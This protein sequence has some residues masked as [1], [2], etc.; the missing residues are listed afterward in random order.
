MGFNFNT[1][2]GWG[3]TTLLLFL[4]RRK[5]NSSGTD[6]KAEDMQDTNVN[7][8]GSPVPVVLGRAMVKSPLISYYGDF[9]GDIYTE[10]YGMHTA[11][12]WASLIPSV[13]FAILAFCSQPSKVV[14]QVASGIPVQ[15]GHYVGQTTGFGTIVQANTVEEGAKNAKIIATV[16]SILLQILTALFSNHLGRTTIQKGFKYYLGW[17][18]IICWSGKNIGIK[19]IWMDVYDADIEDCTE[20]GVWGGNIAWKADNPSGIDVYI[21]DENMFGGIDEGGGFI[22]HIHVY[23]GGKAQPKDDWMINQMK[24]D[25]IE[26]DLR[27]LT[28]QYPMYVTAVIP[29]AY[30]GKRATIPEMWFEIVN[31][32]DTLA[33]E[34]K[35]YL[36]NKFN[37][38]KAKYQAIIDELSP[39]PNVDKTYLQK[40]QLANAQAHIDYLN[41]KTT[42]TLGRLGDDL[43]PAE[44]IYEVLINNHWG[45][46]YSRDNKIDVESLLDLGITC[47]RE[48]LG[49]S[50]QY[51]RLS[52]ADT[53][54]SGILNHIN[55]VKYDDPRTGKL[56]FKLIRN[57]YDDAELKVFDT[58][59]CVDM[60][61]SR[62]DW[63]ETV[64]SVS[65][66]FIDASN[67][68]LEGQ[69]MCV[70]VAN[71]KITKNQSEESIDASYFTTATNAK[72][73]AQNQLLSLAYPLS[74]VEIECNRAGYDVVVGE[75]IIVTWNPYGISKMVFRVTSIDYGSL[76]SGNIKISAIE[77]V[78]GF[79]KLEYSMAHGLDWV[80]PTYVPFDIERF[81]YIE[82]PYELT[83]S[84][85]TYL[86]AL[87]IQPSSPTVIWDVWKEVDGAFVTTARSSTWSFGGKLQYQVNEEYSIDNVT[88]IEII[89]IGYNSTYQLDNKIDMIKYDPSRYNNTSGQNLVVIDDEIISYNSMV[90]LTN[91]HYLLTGIIRGVYDTVPARHTTEAIC[92]LLDF[93]LNVNRGSRPV[94]SQGYTSNNKLALLSETA[95][96]KQEFDM[97]KVN[98]FDT[99]RRSEMPS[100]MANLQFGMDL[101][102]NT[103]FNYNYN[104]STVFSGDI[105]F[106]FIPRNKF[107]KVGICSP[108]DTTRG[109]VVASD[110]LNVIDVY[111]GKLSPRFTYAGL[112]SSGNNVD[113]ITFKWADYCA[114]MG[115]SVE[116]NNSVT[117]EIHTF[118]ETKELFSY[119]SYHK[120]F[121]YTAPRFAGVVTNASDAQVYADKYVTSVGFVLP[122]GTVSPML[123][124]GYRECPLII[125]GTVA[126]TG[127]ILS[128]D[129]NYYDMTN[130]A[131]QVVGI[132]S[133]GKAQLKPMTLDDKYIIRSN[134]NTVSANTS[135]GYQYD[136]GTWNSYTFK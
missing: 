100:V 109:D 52:H 24:Q 132:D 38:E 42:W 62:L 58:D 86:Y 126:T 55:G 88:G 84:L 70:D 119:G 1:L 40:L 114:R 57:D 6:A 83:Y 43:N 2:I 102:V 78:F 16:V 131:Y 29:T 7:S 111:S 72:W 54:I 56:T 125:E 49:V 94:V 64:S 67:K 71:I 33:V 121:I 10:E 73:M 69:L 77:D 26:S 106:K 104:S 75:P 118:D 98:Q 21:N 134:F 44:A 51:N 9:R 115:L 41:T 53:L 45:C 36:Q 87:A 32:P 112:D 12:D 68:Y 130:I 11:F 89:P 50:I 25:T 110:T 3:I 82:Y 13:L 28:P 127:G 136:A 5:S 59:N 80:E 105:L 128:Y 15:A 18:H 124:L 19:S 93:K 63:S 39:I 35:E 108:D 23:L 60:E 90:K 48:G 46:D 120:S 97:G 31:Y 61:F 91:G 92:Y 123:S 22:G 85:D 116:I 20:K 37:E 27:G 117:M 129:G 76:E 4:F 17:Q 133:A 113:S 34:N 81:M 79:D 135:D 8:I 122:A 107:D 99:V 14:G 101:D 103:T 30:I 95:T 96:D 74:S 47:E 66:K 65:A